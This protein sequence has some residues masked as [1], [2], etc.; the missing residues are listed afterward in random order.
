MAQDSAKSEQ[1][2]Q[3]L[4]KNQLLES[5]QESS[6]EENTK[7]SS[8]EM[9]LSRIRKVM[10]DTVIQTTA[11]GIKN[12]ITNTVLAFKL[13]WVVCFLASC[14]GCGYLLYKGTNDYLDY[15]VVT[16]IK[17]IGESP[18]IFPTVTICNTNLITNQKAF[19]Y[20]KEKMQSDP[21][22]FN[23]TV[24]LYEYIRYTNTFSVIDLFIMHFLSQ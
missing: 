3:E 6:A 14:A 24:H 1:Y 4:I 21:L 9:P 23:Y 19:D 13:M 16:T 17:K 22:I 2:D 5:K 12:I 7:Q 15:E 10:T 18:T 8:E 11:H 20:V